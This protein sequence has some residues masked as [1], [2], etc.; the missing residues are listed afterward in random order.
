MKVVFY[1]KVIKK[2]WF[3]PEREDVTF[4]IL[5][6]D[7]KLPPGTDLLV[8]AGGDGTF[9]E[10]LEIVG[11]SGVPIAGVNFGRLGFLTGCGSDFIGH[12]FDSV[13]KRDYTSTRHTVLTIEREKKQEQIY[14]FAINEICIQRF[15]SAMIEV[16]VKMNG[17]HI[18]TYRGDGIIVATP[19]GSTAYSLSVGGPV[20]FPESG[21]LILSP[22]A[23]HNLNVRPLVFPDNAVL[24]IKVR[25]RSPNAQLHLDNR[26]VVI[27]LPY[28]F[29]VKKAHFSITSLSFAG[30]DFITTLREKL[31]MGFD[32]RNGGQDYE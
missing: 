16:G 17:K 27:D 23:P 25:S 32:K 10:A 14:P 5:G 1:G 20:V 18:S 28:S 11:D 22:I 19:T 21:V 3:L 26:S 29:I 15:S 31:M 9:L 4:Q 30:N 6:D 2:D 8:T 24:E 12:L 13:Q 7:R